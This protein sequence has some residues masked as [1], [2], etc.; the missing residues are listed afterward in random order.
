[1]SC[2]RKFGGVCRG[3]LRRWRACGGF[4]RYLLCRLRERGRHLLCCL[5]DTGYHLL[6]CLWDVWGMLWYLYLC[7][8]LCWGP[9]RR[10]EGVFIC[11]YM[12]LYKIVLNLKFYFYCILRYFICYMWIQSIHTLVHNYVGIPPTRY[13][14]VIGFSLVWGLIDVLLFWDAYVPLAC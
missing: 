6:C 11:Q 1:M 5:W 3:W 8:E 7:G 4:W 13:V 2:E 12:S 10:C 9:Y 14:L